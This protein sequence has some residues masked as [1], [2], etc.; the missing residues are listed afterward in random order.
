MS[1]PQVQ[2]EETQKTIV[3]FVFGLL[4][5]GLLVWAF[6]G[7]D[8]DKVEKVT[9]APKDTAAT[10]TTKTEEGKTEETAVATPDALPQGTGALKLPNQK[11]GMTVPLAGATY[12]VKEGWVG[13]RDYSDGR[14][15]PI[16]GVVRFSDAQGLI[17]SDIILQRPTIAGKEY[18]VVFFTEDGDRKFNSAADTMV[19]TDLSTFKAE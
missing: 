17:P 19:Q 5:G 3:S 2:K 16:L 11:A 9:P 12:P 8:N 1:E 14:M 7:G 10:T 13:V 18:A 6:M 15:G 4:I